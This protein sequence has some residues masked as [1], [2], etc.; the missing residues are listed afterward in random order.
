MR[1]CTEYDA[2]AFDFLG[3]LAGFIPAFHDCDDRSIECRFVVV[4]HLRTALYMCKEGVFVLSSD[5]LARG[6]NRAGT[7][8]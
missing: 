8:L 6:Y 2:L 7:H 5:A 3:L 1:W 4:Q